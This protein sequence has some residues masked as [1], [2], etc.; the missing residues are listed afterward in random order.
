[1]A[2]SAAV[3]ERDSWHTPAEAGQ[4]IVWEGV[5]ERGR[6]MQQGG[7][8]KVPFPYPFLGNSA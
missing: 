4:M 8:S 5:D 6:E 1:M 2:S 3:K 7:H